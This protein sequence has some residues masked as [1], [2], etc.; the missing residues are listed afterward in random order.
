[1]KLIQSKLLLAASI[2]AI[3][4]G[5]SGTDSSANLTDTSNTT[6]TQKVTGLV[7]SGEIDG[8]G[9]VIVNGV[10]YN[11]DSAEVY[12][13]GEV[14]VET[15]LDVG[16]VVDIDAEQEEGKQPRAKRID[17]YT[18]LAGAIEAIDAEAKTVTING[19]IVLLDAETHLDAS[20]DEVTLAPLK[21]GSVV[22][23]SGQTDSE[24][25]IIASHIGLPKL[26]LNDRLSGTVSNLNLETST[27]T[28]DGQAV[29]FS[30]AT[31]EGELVN[32]VR[33][34]VRGTVTNEGLSAEG[35]LIVINKI[36][37]KGEKRA[38]I[39]GAL[40]NI[41]GKLCLNGHPL[42]D[43][44]A[45]EIIGGE[46]DDVQEGEIV[47]VEGKMNEDGE[48][49]VERVKFDLAATLRQRGHVDAVDTKAGTITID[50]N[51][52]D[53]EAETDFSDKT[54][55]RKRYLNLADLNAGDTVIVNAYPREHQR[56]AIKGIELVNGGELKK[57][58]GQV[59]SEIASIE[60][61]TLTTTDGVT[62]TLT[63]TT[64]I[65]ES[66][67]LTTLILGKEGDEL[68]I[69]GI[70]EKDGSLTASFVTAL[71]AAPTKDRTP[72]RA[73]PKKDGKYYGN[74]NAP[75]AEVETETDADQET[76]AE[77]ETPSA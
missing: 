69:C 20:I 62:V 61:S 11:S 63:E 56:P 66:V 54:P 7:V 30:G 29:N 39:K 73:E 13:D 21:I 41:D 24:G 9:S 40:H 25:N 12:V 43:M 55:V 74:K 28:I 77:T 33:V 18:K 42:K 10:H 38:A 48:I 71:G 59:H 26:H 31:I 45:D 35:K 64:K 44:D 46:L 76:T 14:A 34:M 5:C 19:K 67:D 53:L 16:M 49:M 68:W 47:A 23:I 65:A 15:D 50:G 17:F 72:R 8:F 36:H 4:S 6:A 3:M 32:G 22:R 1:M 75:N 37:S 51:T 57:Y 2:A 70:F 58:F 60:G 27:L 52:F